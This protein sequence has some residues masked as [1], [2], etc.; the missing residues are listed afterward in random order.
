[1]LGRG[2]FIGGGGGVRVGDGR[3]GRLRVKNGLVEVICYLSDS[4]IR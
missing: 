4:I 3:K 1:M 2:V